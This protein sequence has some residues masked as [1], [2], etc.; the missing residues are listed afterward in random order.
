MC[1]HT[2]R[3]RQTIS[4][5]SSATKLSHVG[6]SAIDVW[7]RKFSTIAVQ[8]F[9]NLQ[10]V[11]Q[12]ANNNHDRLATA[13]TSGYGVISFTTFTPI[14]SS[15]TNCG[16]GGTDGCLG[17]KDKPP[18]STQKYFCRNNIAIL[19]ACVRIL[20]RIVAPPGQLTMFK[21]LQKTQW[22]EQQRSAEQSELDGAG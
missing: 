12:I 1:K 20:G 8:T 21:Q 2:T 3:L 14:S 4:R 10:D 9:Q 18:C 7:A 17:D 13:V 15:R 22:G 6:P 5:S 16:Y 19:M 11:I